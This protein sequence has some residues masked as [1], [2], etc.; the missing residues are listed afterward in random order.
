ME[1][2]RKNYILRLLGGILAVVGIIIIICLLCSKC[3]KKGVTEEYQNVFDTN[4]EKMIQASKNYYT[5]EKLPVNIHDAKTLK[6]QEMMDLDIITP[7]KDAD[8]KL[9]DQENSY[10]TITKILNT[11]YKVTAKLICNK[12]SGEKNDVIITSGENKPTTITYTVQFNTDGGNTIDSQIVEQGQSV[13]RPTDPSKSGYTFAGWYLDN[14]IYN[15]DTKI[16]Q[17]ITLIAKWVKNNTSSTHPNNPSTSNPSTTPTKQFYYEHAPITKSYLSDWTTVYPTTSTLFDTKKE[18]TSLYEYHKTDLEAIYTVATFTK[19]EYENNKDAKGNYTIKYTI[20]LNNFST[21]NHFKFSIRGQQTITTTDAFQKYKD[22]RNNI[23]FYGSGTQNMNVPF[24]A[25]DMSQSALRPNNYTYTVSKPYIKD[26]K[27]L[28]DISIT[29]KSLGSTKPY[30]GSQTSVPIY[31]VGVSFNANKAYV[32][33][34]YISSN[35][36]DFP[37]NWNSVT[38]GNYVSTQEITFYRPYTYQM[39]LSKAIWSTKSQVDGYQPTGKTKW[40]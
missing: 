39:D 1:N 29:V 38:Q 25:S 7:F 23:S 12:Q 5:D 30:E 21:T 9:C 34:K 10:V 19:N 31:F 4:L 35:G 14:A 3:T 13:Q 26:N 18:K 15:F 11:Q 37:A 36:F 24:V 8:N 22:N 33:E 27:V 40:Q 32:N 16:N 17:D 20:I 2:E 6:L 28:V